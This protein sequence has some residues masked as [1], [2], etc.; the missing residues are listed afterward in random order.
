[1]SHY[2]TVAINIY[3]ASN[4]KMIHKKAH[5][6]CKIFR[7]QFRLQYAGWYGLYKNAMGEP[8]KDLPSRA[9]CF[10]VTKCGFPTDSKKCFLILSCELYELQFT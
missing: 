4:V 3:L 9:G 10:C 1:M 6:V 8:I 2:A 5:K 7:L